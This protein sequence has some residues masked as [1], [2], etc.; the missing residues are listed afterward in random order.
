MAKE[1]ALTPMMAQYREIKSQ[2]PDCILFFRLGDF[3]EMFYEDAEVAARELELVLTSRGGKEAAPMCGVPFH[4][5]D[6]YL[7]RLVSKGYRVAICE[8]MEDPRQA[9]GL[10]R[11]E[12]IRVVTPGTLT[13]EKALTPG[14]NNY[15]AAIVSYEGCWGLAWADVSTGEFMFTSCQDQESLVDELVRLLPSEYLLPAELARDASFKRLLQVYTR[16]V[17]TEWQAS[18]E[19]ETAR[20]TLE[21][22]FG[23]GALAGVELPD[24][25]S[26]AAAMVLSFLVTTQHNSLA[27]LEVP[28]AAA[29][30]N[31]MF[32][33][34]ATRRNLE[35]AA[36]GREQRQEGSLLWVLDKTL[37]AMGAR[38]LRRW[39]DQPLVDAG[40]I[41]ERQEAVAELVDGFILRQELRERLQVV[42]D[43]E[44]LAGRVAYGTASGRELQALRGSLAVIPTILEL[45]AGVQAGLLAQVRDRLDPLTDLVTLL[46]RALVD[47]PPAG[48][49]EGGI[50]RPG[51]NEEVDQ[52]RQAAGHGREWIASL[53]AEE[54]ERTGIKSLKVGYNRVF[55]YYIEV[56][57]PN[58][59]M[60]PADYERKQTLANA[61]RFVTRRL[62]ELERQVLGAEE[63][64]VQ[65]EYELFQGLREEVLAVLPRIQGT[66]RAL[67][68][69]DALLS[70]ATVAVDNNYVCPQVDNDA[71]I[72]IEQGRHPVVELVGTRGTF[73]PN[74]TYLDGE[75]YIHIITGPNMAGKSTY[76]RQVAL[77]VLMAQIGSFVP[78]RRAQ[79]GLVDRIFTRVGAADDIFAG[80][81]TFMVEMQEVANILKHA[82]RRSLVILDEV[83]R[84]TSTADGLSIARAVTEYIHD[85]VGSRCLF[86]THYHELVKLAEDFPGIRNYCVAVREEGENITFLRTIV[87]GSTDKSY[88]IHVARLAG[89]PEPVLERARELLEHQPQPQAQL[90]VVEK[91]AKL[92]ALGFGAARVLEELAAYNL[93]AVTPLEAMEQIFRWQKSLDRGL[94]IAQKGRG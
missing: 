36:A 89:L 40:A 50:I 76:I 60:V 81:S 1:Q 35:L 72:T 38:T 80:Q 15:L 26:L 70:L 67:G 87:P 62:Q 74:D 75:H 32:L 14:G 20:K 23:Q 10:V 59:P 37:T 24:P 57:R 11:R 44:R 91:P 18:G 12:V 84:G 63:R 85:T 6:S 68:V 19:P 45:T 43:L 46:G 77:I 83:G 54:R 30:T 33:D 21:E 86:A 79:I 82:T 9:R 93:M 73:V 48:I 65:L 47:D 41:R 34:Q 55:G 53:E 17:I 25:A 4:A 56:T 22:H 5:V 49:T 27:H 29:A 16:G 3:Y 13:D 92:P 2:Y 51:Y 90:R 58:L 94:D 61:E 7:S 66:A 31:R 88:G 52:L 71:V 28:A 69:L 42:R 64:L 39:L 78:A 8:Q